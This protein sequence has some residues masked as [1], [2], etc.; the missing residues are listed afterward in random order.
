MIN[1]RFCG[2][3]GLLLGA[4]LVYPNDSTKLLEHILNDSAA[5]VT[6]GEL[7]YE[8]VPYG[9]LPNLCLKMDKLGRHFIRKP[10]SVI[11]A[12]CAQVVGQL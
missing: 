4:W 12:D 9:N 10:R 6:W 2:Y 8:F 7:V 1:D 5:F 3:A 11:L